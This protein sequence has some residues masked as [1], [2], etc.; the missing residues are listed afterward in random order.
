M[1]KVTRLKN[2]RLFSSLTPDNLARVADL[3]A[4]SS[5]RRGS[6]L[7]RQDESG[8]TLYIIDSGEAIRRQT[9]LRGVQR[10]VG[11]M[12][13]GES[14]G[15]DALVLGDAYGSCV[16][17]TSDIK[18]LYI[19]KQD[20]DRLVS[21]HPQIEQQLTIPPLIRERLLAPSLP[22]QDE[23][24]PTLLLRRKHWFAFA[25]TLPAPVLILLVLGT[26]T[27]LLRRVGILTTI[28]STLLFVSVIPAMLLLWLVLDW[29]NDYYLV[30][31]KRVLHEERV[32]LL[33]QTWDEVPLSKIQSINITRGFT[34]SMLGFGTL[35]IQTAS[36]RGTMALPY[37]PDPEGMQEVIFKKV[38]QLRW[39]MQQGQR[40]E[41]RQELLRQSGVEE[42]EEEHA[43]PAMVP[44]EQ[45]RTKLGPLA[46]FVSRRPLLRMRYNHANQIIWR[47]HWLFL[48]KRIYLAL[49]FAILVS[50]A[51]ITV[52]LYGGLARYRL[53]LLPA[54]LVLW[55]A[56]IFWLWWQVEDWRNDVYIVTDRLIIDIEKRPLFF[57][58]DRK[59]ATLDVIQN[60]SLSKRGILTSLLNYGDVLIQIAGA[61]GTFTFEGVPQ[62]EAVQREIFR[63]VED[64]NE[65][66]RRQ[67]GERRKAELSTWFEVY[68]EINKERESPGKA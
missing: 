25:R 60:V 5:Y 41:I 45:A 67:Q 14:I 19:R 62:P 46:R 51:F 52:S 27:W 56:G 55:I 9:D 29:R 18:V 7:C 13:E 28:P 42:A 30:T 11:Y 4:R 12:R 15:E 48:L 3:A 35:Q 49:P 10:P 31:S 33:Y 26:F 2:V 47:K 24:E 37:V 20:F 66:Q 44:E 38:G 23:D 53:P 50:V 65:S 32:L 17:A 1:D 6:Y 59:Q 63:R 61:S 16:Q 43:I 21:E 58:E 8:D 64:Y 57:A 54:A 39:R 36:A 40:D 34:G 22:W 68:Q